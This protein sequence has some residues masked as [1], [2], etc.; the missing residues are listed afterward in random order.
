MINRIVRNGSRIAAMF[1]AALLCTSCSSAKIQ[2]SGFLGDSR[3]YDAMSKDA[4][5]DGVM[6]YKTVPYPLAGYD[7]FIVPPVSVYLNEQGQKREIDEK[8]LHELANHFREDI[9]K[10]LGT[11]YQVVNTPTPRVAILRIAITDADP[12][13]A[14]MNV[15]PGSLIL[16]GGLGG[17]SME[18]DLID[19]IT[20]ER[21]GA[22]MATSQGKRY[23]Y[24][25]GLSKWGHTENVLRE[26]AKALNERIIKSQ[27]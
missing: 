21:I 6:V 8:D 19:S 10:E 25:S 11:R 16:G 5:L 14:L 15:H 9:I 1:L 26:W 4:E 18:V 27:G 13:N 24:A 20:M 7:S 2:P 3:V 12:S 23:N 17:A 22:V